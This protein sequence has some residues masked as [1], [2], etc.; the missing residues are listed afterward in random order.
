MSTIT[1]RRGLRA[2]FL[3]ASL[4]AGGGLAVVAGQAF[5]DESS[6]AVRADQRANGRPDGRPNGRPAGANGRPGGAANGQ[7]A[8]GAL[9]PPGDLVPVASFRVQTGTQNYTCTNGTLATAS[10]PEAR[11]VSGSGSIHHFGGPSWQSEQDGSLVTA[12]KVAESPVTGAV[13]ELLLQV[14]SHSG[15]ANGLL[16]KVT[17]IQRLRTS[18]GVAPAGP[19]TA[20]AHVAYSA[21]YVFFA[22]R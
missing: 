13:A 6:V 11:L 21:E 8:S 19:C 5:A 2:A 1:R 3:A 14:N 7:P 18:G 20:D 10:V 4:L 12:A 9:Q 17:H 22:P 16:S 15:D